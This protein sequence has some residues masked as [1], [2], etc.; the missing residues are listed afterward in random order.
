MVG[1]RVEFCAFGRVDQ[2][3]PKAHGRQTVPVRGVRTVFCSV[4]SSGAAQ[5]ETSAQDLGRVAASTT[6]ADRG[7][8]SCG[9]VQVHR[10]TTA[11]TTSADDVERRQR[12]IRRWR[13]VIRPVGRS[14]AGQT[15][16]GARVR[17]SVRFRTFHGGE[18]R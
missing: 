2:T 7:P 4:R 12:R 9:R 5:E 18:L 8:P 1:V 14:A 11:E 16:N 3:L 13:D 17:A 6:A 15:N 10:R